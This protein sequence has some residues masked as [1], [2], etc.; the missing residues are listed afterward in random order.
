MIQLETNPHLGFYTVGT[1][2][3]YS[4]VEALIEATKTNQF[5]EWNFNK[6]VFS[7][8][9]WAE[10]PKVELRELYRLRAAQL[11]EKYD[12]IRIEA[13]GGGDSTTAIFSFLL[14]D[15]HIDE[16]VFRY[17]KSADK[18]LNN[19]PYN[20]KPENTLSEW[21]FAAKPLL[22]WISVHYPKVKIT[23]HDYSENIIEKAIDD[24]W[25]LQGKDYFQL[26]H[27]FKHD[28]VGFIDH[29]RHADTGKSICIL[30]GID[31]PKMCIR[32]GQWYLYFMDLQANHCN[33]NVQEYT[34][35]T[36]EYFYWTPDLPELI[37][38]QAH[39]IKNWFNRLENNHLQFLVK[40]PSYS[41]SQR[42]AYEQIV[43]PLIYPEYDAR[44]FQTSKPTNSFYNEMDHWFYASLQGTASHHIQTAGLKLLT[45]HIDTKFF[46][47]ELG[48]EVGFVGFLSPFYCIGPAIET[49]KVKHF[50]V[51]IAD[52]VWD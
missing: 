1:K 13:S 21:N 12:W 51:E 32:D 3:F 34:N 15:I 27:V 26:A 39:L 2:T 20:T 24:T 47:K 18:D 48:R 30:Y 35:I 41:I 5:P 29:R 19:D 23:M 44:T 49:N 9:N 42:T 28:P 52:R 8:Q 43:K 22:D 33:S 4:K 25:V 10:E 38:K 6:D 17:P 7:K 14:N 16:I 50:S 31:K 45:S 40:W 46:N 36:N 37:Q 11:R